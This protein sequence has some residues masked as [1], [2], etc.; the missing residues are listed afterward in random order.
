MSFKNKQVILK[1]FVG[2]GN[3]PTAEHFEVRDGP[4]PDLKDGEIRLQTLYLSVDPYMRGRMNPGQS[5]VP[6]FVPGDPLSGSGVG[7]VVESKNPSYSVGEILTSQKNLHGH[8]NYL[9]FLMQQQLKTIRKLIPRSQPI[10]SQQ[11]LDGS[12]CLA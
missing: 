10:S 2:K 11:Q 12:E 7:R 5:Y 3:L 8:S 9:L 6:H 1:S 4:S